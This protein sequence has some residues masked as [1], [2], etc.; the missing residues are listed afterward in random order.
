MK[1]KSV[2]RVER[3]VNQS[4]RIVERACTATGLSRE[5]FTI[6]EVGHRSAHDANR[7]VKDYYRCRP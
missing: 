6:Y 1:P 2:I 5:L 3:E 4:F 7:V